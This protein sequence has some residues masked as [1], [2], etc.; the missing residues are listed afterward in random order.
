MFNLVL[1]QDLVKLSFEFTSAVR[2]YLKS[3][4]FSVGFDLL[5]H[6][7]EGFSRTELLRHS[8]QLCTFLWKRFQYQNR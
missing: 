7:F 3:D 6:S 2:L 1:F 8:P 4:V 5:D